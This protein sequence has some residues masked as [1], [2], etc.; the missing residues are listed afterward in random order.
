[1]FSQPYPLDPILYIS[2]VQFHSTPLRTSVH[3]IDYWVIF[4][5]IAAGQQWPVCRHLLLIVYK[6]KWVQCLE[7]LRRIA[8]ILCWWWNSHL[9]TGLWLLTYLDVH[10][11]GH[12]NTQKCPQVHT[13]KHTHI[14]TYVL[15]QCRLVFSLTSSYPG[16]PWNILFDFLYHPDDKRQHAVFREAGVVLGLCP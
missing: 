12:T 13:H 11:L 10:V 8:T 2:L 5:H 1:M 15:P 3:S 4:S 6:S 7:K 16:C 14:V 9:L